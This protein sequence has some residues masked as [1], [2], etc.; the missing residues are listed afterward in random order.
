MIAHHSCA[1]REYI[2]IFPFFRKIIKIKDKSP[3]DYIVRVQKTRFRETGCPHKKKNK[4]KIT[5]NLFLK[6]NIR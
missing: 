3:T 5:K 1:D 6:E 4:I 2:F